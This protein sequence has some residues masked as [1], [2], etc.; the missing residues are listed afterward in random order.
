[1]ITVKDYELSQNVYKSIEEAERVLMCKAELQTL[2]DA[3]I[4]RPYKHQATWFQLDDG[5]EH[6]SVCRFKVLN[7][8]DGHFEV[9]DAKWCYTT[10]LLAPFPGMDTPWEQSKIDEFNAALEK[11]ET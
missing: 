4:G 3:Q 9:I 1:M 5:V 6:L 7:V 2:I 10:P 11:Y 8:D